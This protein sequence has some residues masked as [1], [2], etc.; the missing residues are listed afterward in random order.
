M[1]GL[2]ALRLAGTAISA[3]Y[4]AAMIE[5]GLRATVP[6]ANDNLTGVAVLLSLARALSERGGPTPGLR[7]VLLS[8][9]A[10][11]SHQEGMLASPHVTSVRCRPSA[12]T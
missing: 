9:G 5:I 10:E 12:R 2:R 1:L 8:A 7:V 6:G 4:T 3:G 11:E